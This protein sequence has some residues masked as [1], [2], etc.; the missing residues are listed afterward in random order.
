MFCK[1]KE[2]INNFVYEL[3]SPMSAKEF[4]NNPI[5]NTALYNA[6]GQSEYERRVEFF[7]TPTVNLKNYELYIT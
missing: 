5:L 3:Y 7:K 4:I 1:K 2:N 6:L